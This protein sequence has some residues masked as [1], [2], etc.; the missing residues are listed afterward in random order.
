[1]AWRDAQG[2][3]L[4]QTRTRIHTAADA[5]EWYC[6]ERLADGSFLLGGRYVTEMED[7]PVQH[8]ALAHLSADGV[9]MD[10]R[11]SE[12]VG[13]FCDLMAQE[14]RVYALVSVN[15]WVDDGA[16][17]VLALEDAERPEGHVRF[18]NDRLE[19]DGAYLLP[20]AGCLYAAGT[21][22]VN[23]RRDAVLQRVELRP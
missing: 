16:H 2:K 21:S 19:K 1:M 17:G 10:V 9:L 8:G 3:T 12:E 22:L 18:L 5:L 14:G 13:C 20:G 7:H 11:M 23:G 6:A 15:S 4:W